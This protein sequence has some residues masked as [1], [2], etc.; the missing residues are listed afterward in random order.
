MINVGTGDVK[1]ALSWVEYCNSDKDTDFA[2]QRRA[3]GYTT[4]HNVRY[5]GIGNETW[6]CGGLY[7]AEDLRET[8]FALCLVPETLDWPSTG[9]WRSLLN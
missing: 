4:P 6:G 7:D 8:I 3:N 9:I 2:R 5:W 1:E